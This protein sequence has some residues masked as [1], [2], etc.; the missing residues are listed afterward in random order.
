MDEDDFFLDDLDEDELPEN[1]EGKV[2]SDKFF[3][4]VAHNCLKY[5]KYEDAVNTAKRKA[6]VTGY[7]SGDYYIAETVAKAKQPIPEVEVVKI[8]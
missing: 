6:A 5:E 3:V 4:V 1:Q 2:M 7:N 8:I